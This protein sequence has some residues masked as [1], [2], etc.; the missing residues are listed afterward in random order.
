MHL[1]L[2]DDYSIEIIVVHNASDMTSGYNAAMLS[3]DAKYKIYL[4]HDTFIINKI[5][6]STY[7]NSLM[8][9]A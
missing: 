6:Y 9:P 5:Y 7:W 2:P 3:S 1:I 8:I 4:H